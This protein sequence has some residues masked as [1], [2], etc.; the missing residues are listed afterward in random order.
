MKAKLVIHYPEKEV[1]IYNSLEEARAALTEKIIIPS[2]EY[3]ETLQHLVLHEKVA[4][5]RRRSKMV[6]AYPYSV[7]Q[8]QSYYVLYD[9]QDKENIQVLYSGIVIQENEPEYNNY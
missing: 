6:R 2:K 7:S 8:G 1:I 9:E 5:N 4:I 3:I